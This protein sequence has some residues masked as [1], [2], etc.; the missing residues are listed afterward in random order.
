M[1]EP[2][3][4]LVIAHSEV[5]RDRALQLFDGCGTRLVYAGP[6]RSGTVRA[7]SALL[8]ARPRLVYL[9]DIGM[10]TTVAT[11][12]AKALGVRV[13][14]DTGDLAYELARS[15][16]SRS[17][18][19]LAAVWVGDR[20]V[21]RLADH[22]VV[23][24][25]EH[26]KLVGS[27]PATYAPDL[28]PDEAEPTSGE[29]IRE[30]LGITDEF[31]VGLIGS[32]NWAPR[33]KTAYGWDLI[34]S[35]EFTSP[36]A[37]ALIIGDGDARARL[38]RR[39]SELGVAGRCRFVGQVG[40]SRIAEWV[41]AMDTA[42]STQT[43]D[44]VGAVRT[45]GKLPLYLACGCPVLASDVGE[46][47]RLLGPLGWT[48]RYDGDVDR[49]YPRRLAAAVEA[50]RLDRDGASAR[51]AQALELARSHFDPVTVRGQVRVVVEDLLGRP[52]WRADRQARDADG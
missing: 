9:I 29:Q 4:V 10:S 45:T 12:I 33:T 42:I 22:V 16:G 37:V 34:E 28:A 30:Q 13:V 17:Q 50:W 25:T 36:D 20:M 51:R 39:A 43:N 23:R 26:L 27:T 18:V 47:R 52:G 5:A 3:D 48:I 41:G 32:L 44:D 2:R 24:G 19:G 8:R 6:G 35:L 49:G 11:P 21:M 40:P 31:V 15:V 7:V 46:A 38:E 1:I 14:I